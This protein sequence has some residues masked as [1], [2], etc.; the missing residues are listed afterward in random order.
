[1]NSKAPLALIGQVLMVLFFALAA[2]I[3]LQAFAKSEVISRGS[4]NRDRAAICV[5]NTAETLKST[6]GDFEAAKAI[7]GGRIEN[8]VWT[9]RFDEAWEPAENGDRT[10]TVRRGE[11]SETL[12]TAKVSAAD[13]DGT[14]LF[15]LIAAWQEADG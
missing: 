10:V 14:E 3:C 4:E 15:S 5:Q 13:R 1:M 8:G 2:A 11:G 9:Q 6:H 12:G 7:L